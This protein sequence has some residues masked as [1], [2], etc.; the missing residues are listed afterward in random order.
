MSTRSRVLPLQWVGESTNCE[1]LC[2]NT[3]SQSFVP[4]GD[5]L[6]RVDQWM[7]GWL[8]SPITIVGL[9]VMRELR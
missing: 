5:G 9:V 3:K 8:K 2:W 1:R 7:L 6:N 4:A